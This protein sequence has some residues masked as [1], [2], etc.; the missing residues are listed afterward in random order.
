[1]W[2][3]AQATSI[4]DRL[5]AGNDNDLEARQREEKGVWRVQSRGLSSRKVWEVTVGFNL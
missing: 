3:V 5:S 4:G 2:P 1:M